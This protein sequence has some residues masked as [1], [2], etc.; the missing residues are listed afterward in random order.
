MPN[1]TPTSHRAVIDTSSVL[2]ALIGPNPQ[3]HPLVLLWH[4]YRITPLAS[5]RIPAKSP[6][7]RPLQARRYVN[8]SLR[9]YAPW[10]EELRVDVPPNNPE[11]R[12]KNDQMF[13]DLAIYGKADL[14]VMK[15]E[16]AALNPPIRVAD[17]S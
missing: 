7:P 9:L 11:C 1:T 12:D 3:D 5:A 10:Y 13:V 8:Q 16:L 14:L 6:T 17:D 15:T 2:P 4:S